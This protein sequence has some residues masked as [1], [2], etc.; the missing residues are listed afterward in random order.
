MQS[1]IALVFQ[2]FLNCTETTVGAAR[3]LRVEA[4]TGLCVEN[5][6]AEPFRV[7]LN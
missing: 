3:M 6:G 5:T 7:H 1:T 2:N 4:K